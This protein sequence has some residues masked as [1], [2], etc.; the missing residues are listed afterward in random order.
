MLVKTKLYHKAKLSINS[1][2]FVLSLF[3]SLRQNPCD[4][5]HEKKR[6]STNSGSLSTD[7]ENMSEYKTRTRWRDCV[8]QHAQEVQ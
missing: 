5:V 7:R 3:F 4:I 8:P 6:S 1:I 2:V